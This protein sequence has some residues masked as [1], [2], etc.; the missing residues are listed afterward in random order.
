[1]LVRG[2]QR[3]GIECKASKAPKV[4]RGFWNVLDD[5]DLQSAWVIAPVEE[6]YPLRK[7]VTVS[8]LDYFLT[9]MIEAGQAK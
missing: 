6:S 1:M 4:S 5:L 9:R 7:G 2:N 8:S 3:I